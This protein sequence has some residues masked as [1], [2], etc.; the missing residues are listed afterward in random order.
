MAM[1]TKQEIQNWLEDKVDAVGFAPVERFTDGPE[2][3]HP[4]R[5]LKGAETVIV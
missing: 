1:N 4:E 3:H 2:A 5:M